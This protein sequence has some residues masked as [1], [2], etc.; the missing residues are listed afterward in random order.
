MYANSAMVQTQQSGPH[1]R[2]LEVVERHRRHAYQRPFAEHS[3]AALARLQQWL[4][5]H[6]DRQLILDSGCGTGASTAGLAQRFPECCVLGIDQSAARLGRAGVEPANALR[7]RAPLEDLWRL[8]LAQGI[9]PLRHCLWYPNPWPKPEHLQRRWHGHPVF[10]QLLALGGSLELRSNWRLYV[11]E[12][13]LAL[14]ACGH[15]GIISAIDA[16][17]APVSPFERKYRDSGH[18]LWRLSVELS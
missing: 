7:L 17:D 6:P 1:P 16:S 14:Q 11:D 15:Q 13:A 8:M 2:L 10:Q 9:R 18:G 5:A 3:L 12:F 4:A